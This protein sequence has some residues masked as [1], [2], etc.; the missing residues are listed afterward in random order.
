MKQFAKKKRNCTSTEQSVSK[1]T[2]HKQTCLILVINSAANDLS[3]WESFTCESTLE[4]FVCES[5]YPS[6]AV[7]LCLHAAW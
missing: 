3:D 1:Y 6:H 4:S 5:D 7:C 2:K